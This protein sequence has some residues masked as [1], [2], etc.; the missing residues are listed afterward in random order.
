MKIDSIVTT[1]GRSDDTTTRGRSALVLRRGI[2][3]ADGARSRVWALRV[4]GSFAVKTSGRLRSVLFAC[5]F[6]DDPGTSASA[7]PSSVSDAARSSAF[8]SR[9]VAVSTSGEFVPPP[10]TGSFINS[11]AG[12]AAAA[13]SSG[14]V[15]ATGSA[16]DGS[17]RAM[18][19]IPR[20]TTPAHNAE[21]SI[22][23]R[24]PVEPRRRCVN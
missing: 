8:G 18:R 15:S 7:S 14:E 16:A 24:T 9:V 3:E 22:S 5:G 13:G 19:D 10:L 4:T 17:W 11:V 23:H 2:W 1:E 21:S 6:T 12:D 20:I